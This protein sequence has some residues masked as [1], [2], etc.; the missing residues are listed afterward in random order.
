MI[1]PTRGKVL[2][3]VYSIKHSLLHL[4]ETMA[5]PD[6]SVAE[7]ISGNNG[8]DKGQ[9]VLIPSKAGLIITEDDI[10]YR[11]VNVSDIVAEIEA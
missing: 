4:P 7:V 9:K 11:L 10:K 5:A 3:E 6:L 8:F 2:V 1:I